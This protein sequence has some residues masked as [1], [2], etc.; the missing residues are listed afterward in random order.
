MSSKLNNNDNC[1]IREKLQTDEGKKRMCKKASK[2]VN[3]K[4]IMARTRHKLKQTKRN[5][6]FSS[7]NYQH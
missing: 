5:C 6:P 1:I 7:S 3:K 4:A 2:K